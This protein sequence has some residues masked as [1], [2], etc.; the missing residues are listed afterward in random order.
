MCCIII[1][2][3]FTITMRLEMTRIKYY[4]ISLYFSV[5]SMTHVCRMAVLLQTMY[6]HKTAHCNN[7]LRQKYV[8]HV[9]YNLAITYI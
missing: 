5:S 9:R 6:I 7:Y 4:K 2:F 1:V 3:I 8:T